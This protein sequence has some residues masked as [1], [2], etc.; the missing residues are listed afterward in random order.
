[1]VKNNQVKSA[2]EIFNISRWA[3]K[4][5]WL[6]VCFWI[7]VIAAGLLAFSS[8]KYALFP[9]ITFPVV[10]VNAQAP[11]TSAIETE[12]KLTKPIEASLKSI[13]GIDNIRSS[14]Y[15]GKSAISLLFAVGTN[16]EASTQKTKSV[17]KGVK[18]PAG[19]SYKIIPLNL[20]ESSVVSYA[21]EG[22][23]KNLD[24][25]HQLAKAKIV[26][27][28]EKLAGVLKVSLLGTAPKSA[29]PNTSSLI[30]DNGN[31]I[32]FNGKDALALQVV[33]TWRCQ[34]PRSSG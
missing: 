7:G 27:T 3:I 19:A 24:D 28:I 11:I 8:L 21:I 15:P 23:S 30:P 13:P 26:P 14:T 22:K 25:L 31:L 17:L 16:L 18:L 9:D 10:V 2:R 34:Y 6:T 12:E 4:F 5:S 29:L 32:R 1:M 20:N 33:K